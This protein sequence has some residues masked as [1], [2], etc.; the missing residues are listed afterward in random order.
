MAAITLRGVHKTFRIPHERHTTLTE[1]LLHLFHQVEYE[2]FEALRGV[3][4]TIDEGSFVGI[5]GRN[6]SGKSTL[7]K[8]IAGLLPPDEGEIHVT[9]SMSALLEL[10]LGFS[11]ELTVRENVEL[12]AAVLG[13]PRREIKER[14]EAAITFAELER[15]RDAKLKNLSTGMRA[16]LGFATALQAECD[17][18]LLDEILA[19]GDESFQRKCIDVFLDLKRRRRTIILVT[20][21]LHTVAALC[22]YAI[23][24]DAGCVAAA[25]PPEMA[26]AQYLGSIQEPAPEDGTADAA[27]DGADAPSANGAAER[28]AFQ[29]GWLADHTDQPLSVVTPGARVTLV[30]RATA[31]ADIENPIFGMLVNERDG[32]IIYVT[33]TFWLGVRTGVLEAGQTVEVRLPFDAPMHGGEYIV[34]IMAT[35]ATRTEAYGTAGYLVDFSVAGVMADRGAAALQGGFSCRLVT[36]GEAPGMP[37]E[38]GARAE[39]GGIS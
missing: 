9:G 17:I 14:I 5:I 29:G 20:H 38:K 3:D 13:Y 8:V 24:I 23:Y 1:R 30:C 37:A 32:P 15:F 31:A 12:Y 18:L 34:S 19:V 33:S 36:E 10:G 28:V 27:H 16:R 4:V 2:R 26:I 11:P 21:D 35:D 22:D 6:G 7:L 39:R 25:G